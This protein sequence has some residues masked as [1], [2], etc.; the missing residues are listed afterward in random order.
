MTR[1]T[2]EMIQGLNDLASEGIDAFLIRLEEIQ[3]TY[4]H[5]PYAVIGHMPLIGGP[6]RGIEQV[7]QSITRSVYRTIRA[8]N[9]AAGTGISLMLNQVEKRMD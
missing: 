8:V 9:W 7:Q 6:A 2:V 4:T 5:V 1:E 3:R